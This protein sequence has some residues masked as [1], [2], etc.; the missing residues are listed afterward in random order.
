MFKPLMSKAFGILPVGTKTKID[1]SSDLFKKVKEVVQLERM[2]RNDFKSD[3]MGAIAYLAELE[4]T[5][6][7]GK[8]NLPPETRAELRSYWSD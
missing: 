7:P 5:L 6:H 3:P 8:L 1:L 2:F 4:E